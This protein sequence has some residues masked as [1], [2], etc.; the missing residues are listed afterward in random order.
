MSNR[1]LITGMGAALVDLF[2][3]VSETELVALGS[4]KASMSLIEPETSTAMQNEVRVHTRQPGGSAANSI[5]GIAALGLPTG[6]IGK[7]G[8]DDLGAVFKD[9]FTRLNVSF[10]TAPI[11]DL[12]TGHCLVLVTPDGERTMHTVLGAAVSTTQSDLDEALLAQTGLFFAEGYI[13]DSPT[14]Q[15]AFLNAARSVRAQSGRVGFSLADSF[16][17][18]RHHADFLSL[19]RDEVDI[20]LANETEIAALC[21]S[22]APDQIAPMLR[23]LDVIAAVTHGADG[24]HLYDGDDFSSI[25]AQKIEDVMDLTGAGDQFA[26]GF[27]AGLH[28]GHSLEDAATMGVIAASEVIR[29]F[30]PRPVNNLSAA[31]AAAGLKLSV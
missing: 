23:E 4:P 30:G 19:L 7:I 26:A 14:A 15:E 13:W 2:A 1:P 18:Q 17:V 20:L 5:A 16:C 25:A 29:H 22:D 31:I 24:V 3:D 12:P 6:F 28:K 8:A 27:L 10:T 9:E 21:G 11:N